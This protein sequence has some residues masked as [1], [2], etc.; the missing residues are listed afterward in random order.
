MVGESGSGKSVTA[1]S[2]VGLA[3]DRSVVDAATLELEGET[4]LGRPGSG[5]AGSADLGSA[6]SCRTRWSR[7]TR[8][9]RSAR[10]SPSRCGCTVTVR[11]RPMPRRCSRCWTG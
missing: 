9:A 2:L 10:R 7:S 3:G 5:G 8:C 1:R 11:D 6:T 4:L